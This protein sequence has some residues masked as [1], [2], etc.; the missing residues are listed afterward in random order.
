LVEVDE[1]D[2]PEVELINIST[3]GKILTGN[4]VMIGG[5]VIQGFRVR[6]L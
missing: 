3:R 5:F 4:D 1:I 2:H 6:R